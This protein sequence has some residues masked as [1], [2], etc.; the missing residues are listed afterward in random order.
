MYGLNPIFLEVIEKFQKYITKSYSL[1]NKSCV[2][3]QQK[4][5]INYISL[6]LKKLHTM[7]LMLKML[8]NQLS[9]F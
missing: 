3:N 8:L 5:Y 9:Q 2:A 6:L 7:G 4:M 1:R